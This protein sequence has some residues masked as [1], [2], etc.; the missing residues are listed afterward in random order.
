MEI[1][2]LSPEDVEFKEKDVQRAFESDLSKLEEGLEFIE[3]EV[4]IG[5]GRIDT[6]AFDTNSSRPVFIEYKRRGEFDKDALIQLMDYLSWFARDENRMTILEKIIRQR[7]PD[8]EDFEPSIRLICVVSDI[9]DRV[10]N[11]IYA[12]ANHVKVISYMVA[13]DTGNNIVLVPKLEVDNAEIEP[14]IREVATEAELL[15]KHPHLQEVFND[16][17]AHLEKDG[18]FSYTTARSFRFKKDRVFAITRFRKRYIQLELRVG[19]G[20]V[21]DP[22]FKY[23]RQGE[24]SWGYTYIYPSKGIPDKITSWIEIARNFTG[25]AEEDEESERQE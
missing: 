20:K 24:S 15:K 18:A 6:L 25:E 13:R 12:I 22:D 21:T 11:A 19:K 1:K 5:T 3:S 23:W 17:R 14:Q 10:R 8:I 16:L 4:V 9:D 7:K 2:I